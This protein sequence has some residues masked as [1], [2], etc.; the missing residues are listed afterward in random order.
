MRT[1]RLL[2]VAG[3]GATVVLS[4]ATAV[5]VVPRLPLRSQPYPHLLTIPAIEC[6]RDD[7]FFILSVADEL[8]QMVLYHDLG[9]SI[10]HARQAD[11]LFV[12]DSRMQMGL[13]ED[14]I[15]AE[16]AKLGLRVF[17]LACGHAERMRFM[18][19]VIRKNDL[20]P[21]VVVAVGGE[22]IWTDG[23]SG[24]AARTMAQTRWDAWKDWIEAR[25]AWSAQVMVH[26]HLPRID[27]FDQKLISGW[28]VYR[29]AA[30]GWWRPLLQ[31]S[32]KYPIGF[33]KEDRGGYE[34]LLPLA[35]E[36]E[37]E[38]DGRGAQL[39]LSIVPYSDTRSR[40]LPYLASELGV[41]SVVPNFDGILTSDA[42]HLEPESA[43]RYSRAFWKEFIALPAVRRR[44]A[45]PQDIGNAATA[46]PGP[47]AARPAAT[48]E[49]VLKMRSMLEAY[50]V[51]RATRA[52]PGDSHKTGAEAMKSSAIIRGCR[53]SRAIL[54]GGPP[55]LEQAA[56]LL[57][58]WAAPSRPNFAP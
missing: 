51:N 44:L 38:L 53:H 4:F 54:V 31:P 13:R 33:P 26:S 42:S 19:K 43:Q 32:G 21:K 7:S 2:K 24:P 28:V 46:G 8:S 25:A 27:F 48:R 22:H 11:I 55:L 30:T 3:L 36:V 41:P 16:A 9:D 10:A 14:V 6:P 34:H 1:L 39:I 20:R 17:S 37:K 18:L 58:R 45:L 12:G 35:R 52:L 5:V 57:S 56:R 40:Y 49:E 47:L 23:V 15:V 50:S 29:S